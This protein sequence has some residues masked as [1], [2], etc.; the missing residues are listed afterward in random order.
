MQAV[1]NQSLNLG[2]AFV[3]GKV[4]NKV[5]A[6][7]LNNK[8]GLA[9][10]TMVD[11]P[12]EGKSILNNLKSPRDIEYA[13]ASFGQG[14]AMSPITTVRALSVLANGGKL[15]TPHVVS[16][17]NYKVGFDRKIDYPA[18]R[19][20]LKPE[21]SVQIS[22]MLTNVVDTALLEGQV[23]MEH[24]SL[25]A[26]TGTAQ[27]AGPGGKYYQDRYLHSFFGY[28]PATNPRFLV[29]FYTYNPQGVEYASHTLTAPFINM[30]KFLINYY[31]IPPD[32]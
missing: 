12:N 17:I 6:D 1:L 10:P 32:R 16:Q 23:K 14:I 27:I 31:E 22:K 24:Y 3:A 26:K 11:L 7:Y 5:F 25:A 19:Q 15:V 9:E 8:F 2:A 30:T 20:V 18:P 13:T 4:G 29:F 21:T 28:F